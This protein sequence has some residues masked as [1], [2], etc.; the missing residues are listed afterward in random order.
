L[1]NQTTNVVVGDGGYTARVT[2]RHIWRDFRCLVILPPRPKQIWL[3]ASWQHLLLTM[4]PKIEAT[5]GVLKEK[6][7]LVTSFPRS[8][9]G[10]FIHYL[11]ALLGYQMGRVRDSGCE[12]LI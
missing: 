7:F 6:H 11:R 2:R 1:V 5:F 4:R 9:K 8:V 12:V 3:M 10:Y